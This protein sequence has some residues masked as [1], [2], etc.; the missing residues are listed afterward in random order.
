MRFSMALHVPAN[1]ISKAAVVNMTVS[2]HLSV[3]NDIWSYEK[4]LKASKNLHEE[5]GVLCSA[6]AIL[7]EDTD[8]TIPASKRVLYNLCRE[9][10]TEFKQSQHDLLQARDMP[11]LRPYL[12]GL[13]YQMSGNE[14]WSKTT[15]RYKV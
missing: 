10:E 8:L 15:E 3:I 2:K 12:L 5:G 6:V 13:E 11:Q 14:F 7:A 1:H 9:W 4:E